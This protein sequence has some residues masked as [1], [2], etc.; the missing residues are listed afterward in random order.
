MP[1]EVIREAIVPRLPLFLGADIQ[2][3]AENGEGASILDC[4]SC[5]YCPWNNDI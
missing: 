5:L 2:I 3:G 1:L 4:P